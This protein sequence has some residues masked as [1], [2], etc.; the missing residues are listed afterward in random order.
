MRCYFVPKSQVVRRERQQLSIMPGGLGQILTRQQLV[1]LVEF[2]S[3]LRRG[4]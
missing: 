1:D 3:G 4:E 2:L